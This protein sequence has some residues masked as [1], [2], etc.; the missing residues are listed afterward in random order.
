MST[1]RWKRVK[2][3][4]L[5]IPTRFVPQFW[6]N[7]D[8][9]CAIVKEIRRRYEELKRDT[10]ADSFQK[11][12]L[13]QRTVFVALQLE[14]ME[15]KAAETGEFDPGVYTQ[16]VNAM[17]GLLSKLGLERKAKHVPNL[18]SYVAGNKG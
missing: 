13:V 2:E 11:D 18:K 16:M 14:T 1:P 5:S 12:L 8:G 15:T 10:G 9:R 17:S 6:D 7:V 4:E 3:K